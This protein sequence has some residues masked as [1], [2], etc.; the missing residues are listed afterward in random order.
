MSWL[1]VIVAGVLFGG[2]FVLLRSCHRAE[3]ENGRL[4]GEVR[5]NLD[6]AAHELEGNLA[7]LNGMRELAG[8][9]PWTRADIDRAV[10]L[11]QQRE[12]N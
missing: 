4:L 7:A 9:K 1:P 10:I 6:A 12:A 2:C 11:R 5:E 3:V 8:L